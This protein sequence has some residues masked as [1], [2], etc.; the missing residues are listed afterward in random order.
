[1]VGIL[2]GSDE[3]AVK[4]NRESGNRRSDILMKTGDGF[5]KAFVIELK[6]VKQEEIQGTLQGR[7]QELL[8]EAEGK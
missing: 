8:R 3:N 1:M 6:V 7:S 5:E 2:S 4:S